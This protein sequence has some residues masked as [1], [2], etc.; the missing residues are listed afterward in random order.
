MTG[1]VIAPRTADAVPSL[2]YRIARWFRG[3]SRRPAVWLGIALGGVELANPGPFDPTGPRAWI[4]PLLALAYLVFAVVQ[5]RPRRP[6]VLWLQAIGFFT[7]TAV[8]LTGL[9][10]DPGVGRYV[11]AAGWLGH[12]VW[13]LAHRDGRVVPRWYVEFCV[14]VDVLIACS[15]LIAPML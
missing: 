10:V 6:S 13:D 1:Y 14:P 12:A 5:S 9:I 8:A 2:G 11:I 3:M 7:F 4:L 15:L